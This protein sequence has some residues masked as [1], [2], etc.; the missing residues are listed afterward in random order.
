M[1]HE[2]SIEAAWGT[3]LDVFYC[4]HCATAHLAPEGS[5]LAACPAC[6]HAAPSPETEQLR[7]EPPELVVPFAVGEE[8]AAQAL[9][10]WARGVWFRPVE[11]RAPTLLGRLAH[12]Y[13]PLWLVDADVEAVWQAEVG[14]DYQAASFREQYRGGRWVSQEVTETR[15]RWEPR[16]GRLK[17]HYDNVAVPALEGHERWMSRLGEYDLS[18][19]KPYSARAIAHSTVRVPDR[20]PS[21]AWPDAERALASQAAADCRAACAADHVRNWGQQAQYE[22]VHWT[23]MLLPVYVTYYAER[24]G[25]YPVWIN[26]QSG[27]VYGPR[28]MS[29]GK[30][31]TAS[32]I[33]GAA[34]ALLFLVGVLLAVVG[35]A[36]V[37]PA[38]LGVL[39]IVLGV[40]L[41]LAAPIP[42]L[43]AWLGNRRVQE[44]SII[45]R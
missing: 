6:L 27:R 2:P 5:T 14:Y 3:P 26:G 13:L 15:I 32:L 41:G 28:V 31:N 35:A 17:R 1:S 8:R 4:P 44:A 39:L 29:Q 43:W 12:T 36:L 34:A 30:A 9:E 25:T 22:G 24:E 40:L 45:P 10:E 18:A 37:A 42:A 7:R 21:S 20:P 33:L 16:V 38:A 19:R 11:L 23:Q